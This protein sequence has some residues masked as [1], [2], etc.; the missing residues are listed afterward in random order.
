MEASFS[1][2]KT[3]LRQGLAIRRRDSF[4]SNF[5][6]FNKD[7]AEYVPGLKLLMKEK[8]YMSNDVVAEME[9][10]LVLTARR[11]ILCSIN[12]KQF[13]AIIADES[14]YIS[15]TEQ[16]SISFRTASQAYDIKE[17]F[18]GIMSCK[19]GLTADALLSYI[20]D[21]FI[22]CRVNND[23]FIAMSFDGAL[24]IKSLAE[25]LKNCYEQQVLYIHCLAH[26]T[27]LVAKVTRSSSELLQLAMCTLKK[28][29]AFLGVYPKRVKLFEEMQEVNPFVDGN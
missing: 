27:E 2:L 11:Q 25:K 24:A 3:L 20:T 22:R 4:E 15:K 23:K 26:C 6:Q 19:K 13:F 17:E 9:K 21:I 1:T 5:Y 29:Y 10:M 18:I 16:I 12:G 14:A 8:I 7:K 28:L